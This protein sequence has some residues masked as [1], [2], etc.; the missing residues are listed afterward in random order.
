MKRV[1]A[2]YASTT[3]VDPRV[4][5]A[6]LPYFS[7]RFG[8]AGSV[9]Q[10]GQ[11]ARE[12]VDRARELVAATIGTKA[13][14]VVFTSGATEADNFAI[15]GAAYANEARGRHIVTTAVE[16]HAVLEP[17]RFLAARGF[18]V[19]ALPVDRFGMVDPEDALRALRE[20]TILVSIMHANNEIG[21]V[22]PVAEIGREVRKRG[23]VMH[24]DA[25]QSAGILPVRVDD[26]CVDLLSMSAHKRYGPKGV[27][28]LYVRKG[29]RL[30]RIQ[31]GGSH[32]RNRRAGTEAVPLIV[33]FGR[34]MEIA[35]ESMDAEA[36][37]LRTLRDRLRDGLLQVERAHYN[38]HPAQRLPGNVNVS[39]ERTD[40]E[41]L[42][43]ALDF[44]GIAASSGSACTSGSLE[45]S[46]V[47]GAIGLPPEIAAGTVR[48][49]LGRWTTDADVDYLLDVIPR[50]VADLRAPA[51]TSLSAQ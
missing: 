29:T 28:A 50:V 5:D 38:G 40:S 25:T 20:D 34:A 1:Y 7:E 17:C 12:G 45:P 9:H 27:G 4:L 42:L 23:I 30:S 41:S 48:L 26:L 37:R 33:G 49:T 46:H 32:E 2:D 44:A 14:D 11:D 24:T 8:N 21:T 10:F 22:Q 15:I 13:Q 35:S 19:T 36:A 39:F 16:H 31:H 18:N 43:M 3:P 6:M 47:L 51:K